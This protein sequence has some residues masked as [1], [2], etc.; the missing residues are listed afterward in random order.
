MG[1]TYLNVF[2]RSAVARRRLK[3]SLLTG[4]GV[5]GEQCSPRC[6]HTNAACQGGARRATLNKLHT[7]RT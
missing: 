4:M 5:G 1:A 7:H 3:S 6:M 2:K